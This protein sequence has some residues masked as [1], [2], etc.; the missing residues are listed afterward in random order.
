MERRKV[1]T[2]HGVFYAKDNKGQTFIVSGGDIP[3]LLNKGLQVD[4]K[5]VKDKVHYTVTPLK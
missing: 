5:V 4:I 1:D 3:L 2:P